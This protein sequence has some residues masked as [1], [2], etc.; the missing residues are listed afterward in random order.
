[1]QTVNH[2]L[3]V[4]RHG[5]NPANI[6]REFSYKLIDYSL[7]PRGTRQA[8]ETATFFSNKG[9]HAIYSSPLKRALETAEAIAQPLGLPVTV[10]EEFR[11]NNVGDLERQPVTDENWA[12][13]DRIIADWYAG[14]H[15]VAFPG[16]ESFV[17]LIARIRAGLTQVLTEASSA[18]EAQRI[19]IVA[20][21]GILS[22]MARGIAHEPDLAL[23]AARRCENCSVS[24]FDAQ[25]V[26]HGLKLHLRDWAACEHLT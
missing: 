13:H 4:V 19:V 10:V 18:Q 5:E 6:N 16:G 2:T 15:E 9:V 3:Y 20:H 22:G 21:G 26:A 7:T 8:E 14:R 23:V 1:M 17:G 12:L 11:E 25:L 24:E